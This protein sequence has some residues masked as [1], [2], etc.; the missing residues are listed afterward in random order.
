M[1]AARV[2]VA[3]IGVGWWSGVLCD[4][5]RK[6]TGLEVVACTARS[7]EPRAAFATK[8]GCRGVESFEAVLA[9]RDVEGVLIATPHT[10]HAEQVIAAA[11]AGKHVFVDKPFTLTAADARRA[12]EACRQAGVVLAVGQQRRRL[13]AYRALKRMIDAGELGKV[14]QIEGNFSADIGFTFTPAMWRGARAEAPGGAMTNLGIH[15]VDTYQYL[16]GPIISVMAMVKRVALTAVDIDD[17]SG[18]LFEFASGALGYLGT[19]WVY[20]NR[21]NT[22]TVHGTEAQGWAE[23]DGARLH[24]ARRGQAERAAV[25]LPPVD[26]VAEQLAEFARCVREGGRPEVGGEEGTAAIAVLDAI[27]ESAASG[28]AVAVRQR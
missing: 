18:I 7:P 2:R 8:H 24:V 5:A 20:A 12:T 14:V 4:A 10:A 23:A 19:A 22:L 28:R 13:A 26:A 15:H 16:A 17:T 9:D 21:T 11:R 6:G 27:V 1:S 3:S 25:P